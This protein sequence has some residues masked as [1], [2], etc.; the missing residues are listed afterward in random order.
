M[1]LLYKY[2]HIFTNDN[3]DLGLCDWIQHE[4]HTGDSPPIY[5]APYRIP[6]AQ[7]EAMDKI[8]GELLENGVIQHSNS[9]WSAPA[10]L[11]Q[12]KDGSQRLVIDYRKLNKITRIDP[13]PLP[14]IPETLSMLSNSKYFSVMDTISGFWQV[15]VRDKEKTAFSTVHGHYKFMR[16]PMGLCNAPSTWQRLADL[17][18]QDIKGKICLVYM[19][20]ILTFSPDLSTHLQ[21][22]EEV[23]KR[24]ERA[25]LKLKPKKCLFLKHEIKYLGHVISE[26]GVRPDSDK[27]ECVQNFPLPKNERDIRTFLGLT[28]Y[29]RRHINN[30]A[31]IAKPLTELLKKG[32][33]FNWGEKQQ[34]AFDRL[35]QSLVAAPLLK[36]PDFSKPFYLATDASATAVG[37]ILSQG[38]GREELPVAYASRQLTKAEKNY[39]ATEKECLAVLWAIKY[40]RPYLQYMGENLP[41]SLIIGP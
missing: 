30:Y 14:Q 32:E 19:D 33:K 38:Q 26:D 21:R 39:S 11:V 22:L 16:M 24:L 13:Y 28:G 3:S 4:I 17:V 35:K 18:L 37:A 5:Q 20:D 34:T 2:K 31:K 8:V 1:P 25:G 29:Y 27:I 10:L 6:Y 12:K 9:P 23:F 7:R 36:Y 41:S 40:F 15:A